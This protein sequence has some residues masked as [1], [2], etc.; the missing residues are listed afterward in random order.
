M[1]TTLGPVYDRYWFGKPPHMKGE[2][3]P[4]WLKFLHDQGRVFEKLYY[5]VLL[6]GPF[7]TGEEEKDKLRVMWRRNVSKRADVVAE[8]ENEVW[9]IEVDMHPGMRALGQLMT[10]RHLWAED[11]PIRKPE[12][13][14]LLAS[15][16]DQDL[17]SAAGRYRIQVYII[18]VAKL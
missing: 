8:L 11:T 7:L 14:I 3:L 18:P 1:P 15:V 6:G 12:K 9:I 4:L 17:I 10:Y 5:N 13:L 16:I 2:D